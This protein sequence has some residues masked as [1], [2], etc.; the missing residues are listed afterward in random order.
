MNVG[1]LSGRVSL[2]GIG[3]KANRWSLGQWR[4]RVGEPVDAQLDREKYK[5]VVAQFPLVDAY[6]RPAHPRCLTRA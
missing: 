2:S 1:P 5:H 4:Y 6:F 3:A